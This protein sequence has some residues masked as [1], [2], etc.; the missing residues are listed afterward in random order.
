MHAPPSH[1]GFFMVLP[2]I[3][4]ALSLIASSHVLASLIRQSASQQK[5]VVN[6]QLFH[7]ALADIIRTSLYLASWGSTRLVLFLL[8]PLSDLVSINDWACSAQVVPETLVIIQAVLFIHMAVSCFSSTFGLNK[9]HTVLSNFVFVAWIVG[10]SVGFV[11]AL[12]TRCSGDVENGICFHARPFHMTSVAVETLAIAMSIGACASC[13]AFRQSSQHCWLILCPIV[14][15]TPFVV[16]TFSTAFA[17]VRK[18]LFRPLQ[19]V[20]AIEHSIGVWVFLVYFLRGKVPGSG[21]VSLTSADAS[22]EIET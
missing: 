12:S 1:N 4:V 14:A 8:S 19:S 6:K 20:L 17:T 2:E 9:L 3:S 5:T 10:G 18:D 11:T 13:A 22:I 21:S 15:W 16:L 7:F